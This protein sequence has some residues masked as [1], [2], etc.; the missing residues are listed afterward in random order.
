MRCI[1]HMFGGYGVGMG[2]FGM[3][4]MIL[5]WGLVIIGV[6][7]LVK[8]LTGSEKTGDSGESAE[9]ILRKRYASG[10]I[11]AEEFERMKKDLQDDQNKA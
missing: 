8:M 6:F 11:S 10:E 7:Y 1:M 9:E 3:I 2:G 4:F 5:F